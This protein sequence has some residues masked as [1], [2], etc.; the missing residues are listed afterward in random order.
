M[1]PSGTPDRLTEGVN[2]DDGGDIR[3]TPE[4]DPLYWYYSMYSG[5]AYFIAIIHPYDNA[6]IGKGIHT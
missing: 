3:D 6:D 1:A 2:D 5:N 4:R